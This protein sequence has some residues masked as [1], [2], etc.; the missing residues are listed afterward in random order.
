MTKEQM[1]ELVKDAVMNIAMMILQ[2]GAEN[3]MDMVENYVEQKMDKLNVNKDSLKLFL[4]M[5][6]MRLADNEEFKSRV[7]IERQEFIDIDSGEVVT[8]TRTTIE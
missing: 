8:I 4:L 5:Q 1:R 6:S 2:D 3:P 7:K